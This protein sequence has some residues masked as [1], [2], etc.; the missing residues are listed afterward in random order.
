[1]NNTLQ[2]ANTL[3]EAMGI[4]RRSFV[5][6]GFFSLFINLLML[7]PPLYMLQIYDR[8]LS[9]GSV[10]T[11]VALTLL[12]AFLMLVLG[13]LEW[14]RSMVLIR[15]G[16]RLDG[17][18][19]KRLFDATLDL[20]SRQPGRGSSQPITDLG[21]IRQFLT[22]PGL[23]G[24]FD[25]P[26]MPVYMLVIFL[27]HPL[28]GFIA[29]GGA[30]ALLILA[31]INEL[32]TR[33]PLM[34]A[35]A[36]SIQ[37]QQ[38]LDAKLR[39]VEVIEALGMRERIEARWRE[40]HQGTI[41]WQAAASEKAAVLM[42]GSKAFRLLLQS[43]ILGTGAWLAIQQIVTPGVMIA[44]SILMGRALA[45]IDQ[46]I[47]AWKGFV[48]ARAASAR[49][50][51]LLSEIPP[52]ERHLSLPA[53]K[54][55]VQLAGAVV[56]PPAS[57]SPVLRGVDL[58]IQ[59]GEIVGVIGPSAAGKTTLARVLLGIWPVASGAARLDG[60]DLKLYNRD[61]LGPFLGYLPQDVE[62]FEGTVAENIA[63]FGEIEDTKVVAAARQA[64][65]HEIISQL[66]DGYNSPLGVGG[67]TLSA[68]Q[69]QRI[70]LARALYGDPK[71]VVLDEP[72]SN[73][74][75][76]G[77]AALV[78]AIQNLRQRQAT[79]VLIT[80]RPSVLKVVDKILVIKDG[81]IEAFGPRD[82]ILARFLKPKA[83]PAPKR[84]EPLPPTA[85]N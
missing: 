18:M 39:N 77:E 37:E 82:E 23:F 85:T 56:V 50:K 19:N 43:L 53:P 84:V 6:A 58:D 35:S 15:V 81:R 45:P 17:V 1:M 57:R 70:G 21:T 25:A 12:V 8:V 49:L 52:R 13:L 63:R 76:H 36:Q 59:P 40:H 69:R 64:G 30:M 46:M 2:P 42:A 4:C 10:D 75:E 44:A 24:F 73:L 83:V 60:A 11:L 5:G 7:V 68:G 22:G 54:G 47:G 29:L 79:V 41:G 66:P 14:V 26:W 80:H 71:L 32:R 3:R 65:V 67:M 20:A 9:S 31:L 48:G 55:H 33:K 61:E 72:N 74:D 38:V 27:F 62:L 28:L 51:K 78:A 16:A 34:A